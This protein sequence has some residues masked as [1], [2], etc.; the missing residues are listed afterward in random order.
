MEENHLGQQT[1]PHA[2][3]LFTVTITEAK[4]V[5]GLDRVHLTPVGWPLH[6]IFCAECAP[7]PR[8]LQNL[9]GTSIRL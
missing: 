9:K 8:I 1:V 5:E 7:L 3:T 4:L 6:A 2:G